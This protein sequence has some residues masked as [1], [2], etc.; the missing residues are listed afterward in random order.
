MVTLFY[1]IYKSIPRSDRQLSDS[2]KREKEME[3]EIKEAKRRKTCFGRKR[4]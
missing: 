1:G 4:I 2:R 3:K